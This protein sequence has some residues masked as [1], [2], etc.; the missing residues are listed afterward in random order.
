MYS[1][2]CILFHVLEFMFLNSCL[3][4]REFQVMFKAQ[5]DVAPFTSSNPYRT[6]SKI[7]SIERLSLSEVGYPLRPIKCTLRHGVIN[8]IHWIANLIT[9]SFGSVFIGILYRLIGLN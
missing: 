7:I 4:I 6:A 9:F 3:S 2:S 1:N 8:L 5:T